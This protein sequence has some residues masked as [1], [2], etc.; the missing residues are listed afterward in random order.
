MLF[1]VNGLGRALPNDFKFLIA[2]AREA[3]GHGDRSPADRLFNGLHEQ[4]KSLERVARTVDQKIRLGDL[5]QR[6]SKVAKVIAS[7]PTGIERLPT[8]S[9]NPPQ[10]Y[11][12][13][14]KSRQ[15]PVLTM[16]LSSLQQFAVKEIRWVY[17]ETTRGLWS[18]NMPMS[19]DRVDVSTSARD[20]FL[21]MSQGLLDARLLRYLPWVRGNQDVVV[22]KLGQKL[23]QCDLVL[24]ILIDEVSVREVSRAFHAKRER[25]RKAFG[26]SIDSYGSY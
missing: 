25:V 12:S 9:N 7:A 26:D 20:H 17:M 19:A 15:D 18:K 16:K 8:A 2:V 22:R 23:T 6:L 3:L 11:A 21:E 10:A 13:V 14:R 5:K 1:N 24:T 4:I